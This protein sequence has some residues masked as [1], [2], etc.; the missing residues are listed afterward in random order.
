MPEDFSLPGGRERTKR[1]LRRMP[2][3]KKKWDTKWDR[4]KE[5]HFFRSFFLSPRENERLKR[6]FQKGVCK[7]RK[8]DGNGLMVLAMA[9]HEVCCL[10]FGVL[11]TVDVV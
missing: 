5:K 8:N 11:G 10:K 7:V 1:R 2:R 9:I 4:H 6:L 3:R